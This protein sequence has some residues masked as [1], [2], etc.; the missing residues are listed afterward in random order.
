[1]TEAALQW[2]R[3]PAGLTNTP[4]ALAEVC[5]H[6]AAARVFAFDTEFLSGRSY[7]TRLCLVQVATDER[8]E[9]IDPLALRDL[10][11]LWELVADPAVEKI[12]HAGAQDLTAIW[13]AGGLAPQHVFDCQIAA[14][15]VGI[16]YEIG[17]PQLVEMA[18][19]VRLSKADQYS[20]WA[21]RPLSASQLAY[22]ANDV[23]YLPA[24]H[25]LLL[26]QVQAKGRMAWVRDA[27]REA[28]ERAA[29]DGELAA[30]Y[31][32]T[33]LK[34]RLE[35][36]QLSVL[37]ELLQWREALAEQLNSAPGSLLKDDML[38]RLAE[39]S[40]E[41]RPE[42]RRLKSMTDDVVARYGD[43]L[44]RAVSRGK[45][46]PPARLPALPPPAPDTAET[47]RLM[48][49]IKASVQLICHAQRVWPNAVVDAAQ[50]EELLRLLAGGQDV[51]SHGVM[52]G[53]RRECLGQALLDLLQGES[54][55]TLQV[56][57]GRMRAEFA[58]GT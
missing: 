10:G 8:V 19:G 55:L 11:P 50:L 52:H 49:V 56:T 7:R 26:D 21:R 51:A 58:P 12:C 29:S 40:P 16:G 25:R 47:R 43:D 41:T 24:A 13:R 14:A 2:P 36:E 53:W 54:R 9:L 18:A 34:W 5:N 1:M 39:R 15:L 57:E 44:L 22:A 48:D 42:L 28:C 4:A 31:T 23:R 3:P 32:R 20:N 30:A 6:L 38:A 45:Q 17:V 37:W 35:P 46:L 33:G 27:C